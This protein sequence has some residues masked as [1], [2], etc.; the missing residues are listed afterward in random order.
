METMEIQPLEMEAME[1]RAVITTFPTP[2]DRRVGPQVPRLGEAGTRTTAAEV[3]LRGS[4]R[5]VIPIPGTVTE[6]TAGMELAARGRVVMSIRGIRPGTVPRADMVATGTGTEVVTVELREER[7]REP[8]RRWATTVTGAVGGMQ[9]LLAARRRRPPRREVA[10]LEAMVEKAA[11]ATIPRHLLG[12]ATA[13]PA[14]A[15]T[16]RWAPRRVRVGM[17]ALTVTATEATIMG[18]A[19]PR[20]TRRRATSGTQTTGAVERRPTTTIGAPQTNTKR[21]APAP[22]SAA[23]GPHRDKLN[24][25][26]NSS[27]RQLRAA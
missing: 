18:A 17:E 21:G 13:T 22:P 11:M 19:H 1:M 14:R 2:E 15:S 27:V 10:M 7:R 26:R 20:E 5:G 25:L 12:T 4:T 24:I 6:V 8:G 16:G 3:G 23:P 9:M